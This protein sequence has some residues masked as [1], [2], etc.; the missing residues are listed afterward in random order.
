MIEQKIEKYYKLKKVLDEY[1]QQRAK[2]IL[3]RSKDFNQTDYENWRKMHNEYYALRQELEELGIIK[4]DEVGWKWDI[5]DDWE[6]FVCIY[7]NEK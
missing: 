3:T 2:E 6:Y 7:C 4:Y 5:T 1:R